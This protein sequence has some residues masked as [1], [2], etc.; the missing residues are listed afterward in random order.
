MKLRTVLAAITLLSLAACGAPDGESLDEHGSL[1][2]PTAAKD[3]ARVFEDLLEMNGM[4]VKEPGEEF[5]G[6][7]VALGPVKLPGEGDARF[8]RL[9][10][11]R[12]GSQEILESSVD[13]REPA[14][15]ER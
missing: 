15:R 1:F 10:S 12:D 13:A 14:R 2:V 6:D 8:E 5:V 11:G 3:N 9:F 4:F 7:V